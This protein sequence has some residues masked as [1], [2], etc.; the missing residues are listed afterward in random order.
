MAQENLRRQA[1][2]ELVRPPVA[3]VVGDFD[4]DGNLDLAVV[5]SGDQTLGILLGN[6][7]YTFNPQVTY[8][9]SPLT[10]ITSIAM[11][12]FNDDGIPDLAVA[13]STSSGGAVVIMQG[14]GTGA[15]F[16][17]HADRCDCRQSA[18]LYRGG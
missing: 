11:G 13:G 14:N 3:V 8:S 2:L 12:D 17:G 4:G 15:F 7:D 6:G 18:V 10:S 5:N 9:V 1:R 16:E